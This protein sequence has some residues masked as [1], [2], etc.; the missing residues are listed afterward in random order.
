[1]KDV[2]EPNIQ[3]RLICTFRLACRNVRMRA[4]MMSA[5]SR[6]AH[7]PGFLF[8]SVDTARYR[9]PRPAGALLPGSPS[10]LVHKEYCG[11]V[12]GDTGSNDVPPARAVIRI[13]S[14]VDVEFLLE[15]GSYGTSSCPM[16]M[17]TGELTAC[18]LIGSARKSSEQRRSNSCYQLCIMLPPVCRYGRGQ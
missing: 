11:N 7:C 12:G 6:K 8:Y 16:A 13:G 4:A 1:M 14:T 9:R 18:I 10:R 3:S 2:R 5:A 17:R 15:Y